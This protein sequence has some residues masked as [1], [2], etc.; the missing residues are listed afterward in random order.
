MTPL[1]SPP[2]S[3]QILCRNTPSY[4]AEMFMGKDMEGNDDTVYHS[5][6]YG[7]KYRW[8]K[9]EGIAHVKEGNAE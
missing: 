6:L 4:P 8:V 2:P 7:E 9:K 5:T 3:P 1:S